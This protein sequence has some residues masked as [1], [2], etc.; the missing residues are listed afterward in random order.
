MALIADVAGVRLAN[1][2]RDN[3][4]S[5]FLENKCTPACRLRQ[6]KQ[7]LLADVKS[8]PNPV[9][10]AGDMNTTSRDNTPT[11]IRNEIMIRVTDYKFWINQAISHFIRSD[12]SST[13]CSQSATSMGTTTQPPTT[14]LFVGEPRAG[15]SSLPGLIPLQRRQ[16]I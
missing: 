8:N 9:V 16:C 6:C 10:M 4:R 1:R 12:R 11:S 15:F 5:P 3:R 13:R 14:C 2:A 7:A